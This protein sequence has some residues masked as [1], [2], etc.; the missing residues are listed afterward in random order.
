[1]LIDRIAILGELSHDTDVV[2]DFILTASSYGIPSKN[3]VPSFLVVLFRTYDVVL[4][5]SSENDSTGRA[6]NVLSEKTDVF[7]W[8]LF[9]RLDSAEA[10]S[11][12]L[13]SLDRTSPLPESPTKLDG[14]P[15]TTRSY[16]RSVGH[17]TQTCFTKD[18]EEDNCVKL[19]TMMAM[20]DT[21][22]DRL[23][24]EAGANA[25]EAEYK[26]TS[27]NSQTTGSLLRNAHMSSFG[28]VGK[29]ASGS[30]SAEAAGSEMMD[31]LQMQFNFNKEGVRAF[32]SQGVKLLVSHLIPHKFYNE[33][34]ALCFMERIHP[35]LWFFEAA[36]LR[37]LT[38]P[39]VNTVLK[40]KGMAIPLYLE[41]LDDIA[42]CKQSNPH[43]YRT[44]KNGWTINKPSFRVRVPNGMA[45]VDKYVN[46]AF[47]TFASNFKA[48]S[49]IGAIYADW[50][51][52]NKE[53]V[54]NMETGISGKK[55]KIT[56]EQ[57][58]QFLQTK[59]VQAFST[60]SIEYN[61]PLDKI[62]T[63]GHIKQFLM[64]QCGYNHWTELPLDLKKA[65][66]ARAHQTYPDWNQT[67]VRPYG[68]H[69]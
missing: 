56:H 6:I 57:F 29:S 48:N 45:S 17:P 66:M 62:I 50:L 33:K 11:L 39:F 47:K 61:V 15:L 41:T 53:N 8:K 36:F 67:E 13:A 31:M 24:V 30:I 27:G 28:A 42:L 68:Q 7:G 16:L 10:F 44:S 69:D 34:Y 51:R 5:E 3:P 65:I 60:C 63:Y 64:E 43:E 40:P 54:Y 52:C 25:N 4:L 14:S 55:K 58:A 35:A 46:D 21:I 2:S 49:S 9:P 37:E 12:R 22:A 32:N 26:M 59:L 38:V 20:E 19:G 1:M 18:Q 23:A